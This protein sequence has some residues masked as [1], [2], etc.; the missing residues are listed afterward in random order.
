MWY[1]TRNALIGKMFM[2]VRSWVWNAKPACFT[3]G[4]WLLAAGCWLLAAGRH[5]SFE[6]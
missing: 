3:A 1:M 5:A 6:L 2:D 4:C